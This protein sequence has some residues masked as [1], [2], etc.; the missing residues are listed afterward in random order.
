MSLVVRCPSCGTQN[1][2]DREKASRMRVRC[3]RCS[4]V[5]EVPAERAEL[6]EVSDATFAALVERSPLPV[7]LEF[8]SPHCL[9]CQTFDPVL[10]AF[11][12]EASDQL[13]VAR[14]NLD[15]NRT[16][17]MRYGVTATPTLLVLDRGRE[18]ERIEGA[19]SADALR[20]RLHR[21]LQ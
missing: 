21:Y 16:T 17:A 4:A 11:V 7:L 18:I 1:K 2:V 19:L 5:L 13:R 10:R 3:A 9:Y 8:W 12:P 15:V 14:L 20:Y 6:V